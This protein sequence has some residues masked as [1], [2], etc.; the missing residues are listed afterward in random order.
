MGEFMEVQANAK[1]MKMANILFHDT[2]IHNPADHTI[3]QVI[4]MLNAPQGLDVLTEDILAYFKEDVDQEVK[5]K[6]ED[7]GIEQIDMEENVSN[8][9]YYLVNILEV[10]MS[11]PEETRTTLRNSAQ[12]I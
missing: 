11:L 6:I 7:A 5:Q 3:I 8:V 9:H 12:N 10:F 4:A 1:A 2:V